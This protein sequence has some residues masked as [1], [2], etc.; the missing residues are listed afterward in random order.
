MPF[1]LCNALSTFQHCMTSIFSNLVQECME[2]LMDNFM[3]YVDSFDACPENLS[4]M[5]TRCMD[6]NLV[7]NFE[8]CHFVVNEGIVLGHLVSN[9]G[10]EVDI[11]KIDI[12]TSLPNPT[13]IW[14]VRL[15]L[16]HAGFY[17]KFIK[18]FSKIVLP[19]PGAEEPTHIRP[20]SSKPNW[21]M[22]FELMCDASNSA[23]G[24]ILGQRAGVDKLVHVIA[25]ASRTMDPTQLNYTTIE[26]ELLAIK[27][28]A[29]L[30]LIRWMLLLQEFN[31]E[32]KDK[33]GAENGVEDH[34][35]RIEREDDPMPII[36]EFPD[37]QV[38][39][40]TTPTTWFVGIYNF[41]AASKFPPEASRLYRERLLNDAKYYIWDD[42]YLWRLCND[43]VYSSNFVMQHLETATMDQLEWPGK[44]LIAGSI[45]PPI[46]GTRTNSSPP[47]KNAKKLEWSL[48]E[49]MRCPNYPYYSTKSLMFGVWTSW[50]HSQSL[51]A[52]ISDQASHFCNKAMSSILHKYGVV[53]RIAT[54]YHPRPMTKLN[55][56]SVEIEHRAYWAV[57][58]CNLAYDQAR[59]QRKFQL[60]E[61]DELRLEAYENSRIYKQ[62]VKRFHDQQILRKEFQVDQKVL[63]FNSRKLHSRW[64]GP[65]VITNFSPIFL[66][67]SFSFVANKKLPK[68]SPCR[69]RL[70]LGRC[71]GDTKG[72]S[73]SSAS[74]RVEKK[75]GRKKETSARR[76][77]E[78]TKQPKVI[79]YNKNIAQSYN[80]R[81]CLFRTEEP[82][83]HDYVHPAITAFTFASRNQYLVKGKAQN[84]A[85]KW[86]TS[87]REKYIG[88]T[89]EVI[90]TNFSI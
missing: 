90:D 81:T 79:S 31:I 23:L 27:P 51:M 65:F 13:S 14:E 7:L 59:K 72:Q 61:L 42:P 69:L 35:S 25:Y 55:L 37:E 66:F 86:P 50:G 83:A 70:H 32:I 73:K 3:V 68:P 57:K 53:H 10:I 6:M 24:A 47:T 41:V 44:Y 4:K 64:D 22:P 63:L 30:R 85:V 88:K 45:G 36:D 39:H 11:S 21:G 80:M 20:Y 1:D 15:F 89:K 74:K 54:A 67:K 76:Q 43:Q 29:K 9:R 2:V 75:E 26:K 52:L 62:K 82:I 12:T 49:D 48:V 40:I 56:S 87:S 77:R 16:G 84:H 17:R 5:L 18:N 60:Q 33:K 8:K 78:R 19:L 71:G 58:Q 28:N 34:L 38:L 46:L